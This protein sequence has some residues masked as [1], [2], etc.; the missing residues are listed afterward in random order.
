MLHKFEEQKIDYALFSTGLLHD[1]K[2]GYYEEYQPYSDHRALFITIEWESHQAPINR[3]RKL[4]TRHY[5]RAL[6]Y[7]MLIYNR[8]QAIKL[9][10][11]L[12]KLKNLIQDDKPLSKRQI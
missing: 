5:R 12:E 2:D 10:E 11:H 7:R 3:R 4:F 1:I 8:C 9:P 6:K